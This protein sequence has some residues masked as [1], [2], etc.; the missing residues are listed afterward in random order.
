MSITKIAAWMWIA[1]LAYAQP[2]PAMLRKLYEQN[3][4]D[5]QRQHG[6]FDPHTADAARNLGLF[7]RTYADPKAAYDALSHA[8][9]IDEKVFGADSARTLADVADLATVAPF[10]QAVKLFARAAR[11]SDGAAAARALIALGESA[12]SQGDRAGAIK[13]W[14][15]AL[16]KQESVNPD[17]IAMATILNVLAQSVEPTEAIP[18]L[19][20]ALVLDRKLLGP[21]HPEAGSVDQL[22]AASLLAIGKPDDALAPAREAIAI[23]RAKLGPD[24]P[25]TA[26][27]AG[28]L[29]AVL[30]STRQFREAERFYV[31]AWTTDEKALGPDD[32]TTQDD[33]RNLAAFFRQHG[34]AA[35]AE[36]MEH[37]LI[38]NVAR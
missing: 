21:D 4:A 28:T 26:R 2:D 18:L 31:E 29:A 30:N 25:R 3:L 11:S 19:R 16:A 38:S 5:Q 1:S 20:R 9:D 14:R 17:S 15:M 22:L 12:A 24:H 6:E 23:L 35:E 32:P 10:E 7:L 37:R 8:V 27:A 13:Y 36:E 34:R 33:I